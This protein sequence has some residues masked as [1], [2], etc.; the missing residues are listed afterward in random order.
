VHGVIFASFRDFALTRFGP[1]DAKEIFAGR[2]L[3]V[4]SEAYDDQEFTSVVRRAGEVTGVDLDE[5]VHDFGAFAGS[6]TFPRLY[7]ALFAAA[8]GTRP[9]LLTVEDRI[10]ELVRATIPDAHPPQLLV[11]PLHDDGVRIT[12]TS[13]RRLCV[14]LTGLLEGTA[15]H[16]GDSVDYEQKA[17]IHRG[18]DACVFEV[19]IGGPGAAH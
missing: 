3:H 9:F 4:M 19:R 13:A 1:D 18:D 10:H 14:L 15:A 5:L 11:E 17:C 6:V 8:G 7:P 2:P 16:Y 12:Y